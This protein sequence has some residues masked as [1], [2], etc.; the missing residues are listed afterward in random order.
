MTSR[1]ARHMQ[2]TQARRCITHHTLL[3][4][5][6]VSLVLICLASVGAMPFLR[7]QQQGDWW[8]GPRQRILLSSTH[9]P[10]SGLCDEYP[11][12]EFEAVNN[13]I[14]HRGI[15]YRALDRVRDDPGREALMTV[16]PTSAGSRSLKFEAGRNGMQG[17]LGII[18]LMPDSHVDL[19][20][21]IYD[22][23][24]LAWLLVPKLA[25]TFFDL[26]T[27]KS[28]TVG[29]FRQYHLTDDTQVLME[30]QPDMRTRFSASASGGG[31]GNPED[32]KRLNTP[33]RNRAVTL[34]F[35]DLRT[36]TITLS[37][38]PG[39]RPAAF[40]FAA[41]P[42]VLCEAAQEGV[43]PD[44]KLGGLHSLK[45]LDGEEGS[46]APQ[47]D[48][49][50]FDT[51]AVHAGENVAKGDPIAIVRNKNSG[52][53]RMIPAA[54]GGGITQT[55]DYLHHGDNIMSVTGD[56]DLATIGKFQEPEIGFYEVSV[57]VPDMDS[58]FN[59]W[60]VTEGDQVSAGDPIAQVTRVTR[61]AQQL[62]ADATGTEAD[63][64]GTKADSN[65]IEADNNNTEPDANGT[66][67][68]YSGSETD[69]EV[70][71]IRSPVAGRV[72][73]T[74]DLQR[75]VSIRDQSAGPTIAKI[76]TDVPWWLPAVMSIAFCGGYIVRH[77]SG[78]CGR[79]RVP[80]VGYA[81]L[82]LGS[83]Q[84]SASS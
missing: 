24:T 31:N 13:E 74:A 50:M 7:H 46:F 55:Q 33:Q 32:P 23:K 49:W 61:G 14:T 40:T 19:N 71:I 80:T 3:C 41:H 72:E 27:G 57:Q 43:M 76:R 10:A 5:P 75:G 18:T 22:R 53:L 6:L 66:D 64:N 39:S 17:K 45:I 16:T 36:A 34:T 63:A 54:K 59:F 29:G 56:G 52:L 79:L 44:S 25:L 8:H 21:R 2:A 83:Q 38:G 30:E 28:I 67:A 82:E 1:L 58:I 47:S 48:D 4:L 9:G 69:S 81:P 20:F 77:M 35:E 11:Y 68:D 65:N 62:Q 73:Y 70:T 84:S 12:F 26:N 37:V 78:F 51:W 15:V 60:M 42:S